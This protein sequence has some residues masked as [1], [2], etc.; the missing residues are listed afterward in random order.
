MIVDFKL[1]KNLS[2]QNLYRTEFYL[3]TTKL[4]QTNGIDGYIEA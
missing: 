4:V 3:K 1:N 2:K